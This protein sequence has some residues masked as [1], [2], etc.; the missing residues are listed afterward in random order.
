MQPFA[1]GVV[2][3]AGGRLPT[4]ILR[5]LETRISEAIHHVYRTRSSVQVP[6]QLEKDRRIYQ[7]LADK[8]KHPD[9][10]YANFFTR[11]DTRSIHFRPDMAILVDDSQ[12]P[13]VGAHRTRQRGHLATG[14]RK[15]IHIV[16]VGYVREGFAKAKMAEERQQH[17]LLA[18]LLADLGWEMKY[19]T[20]TIGVTGTIYKDS[21][22]S[23]TALGIP[24][25]GIQKVTQR[26]VLMTL[27]HTH[28]L[29]TQSR[30]LDSHLISEAFHKPP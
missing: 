8:Y 5:G 17:E 10:D 7:L 15:T 28:G 14:C 1:R 30:E 4:P 11:L 24:P 20:L 16:E 22:E 18:L 6:T 2:W 23:M 13:A 12:Q 19:H 3:N 25:K 9:I 26:W 29:V 27:N 21:L